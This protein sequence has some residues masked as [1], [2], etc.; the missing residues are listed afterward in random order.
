MKKSIL[1]VEDFESIRNFVRE[2]LEKKGYATIGAAD[3][4]EAFEV[5]K[6]HA[7]NLVLSDYNMP[8]CTGLE[9]LH[10]IKANSAT[11]A[12]PVIFLTTESDP[13]KMKS[14]KEAGLSAWVRK[15]YKAELFFAQIENIISNGQ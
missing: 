3:G 6:E 7:V 14:A 11:S 2:T 4:N 5:I 13:G 1:V 9:L 12:I 15:P 10:K 8:N